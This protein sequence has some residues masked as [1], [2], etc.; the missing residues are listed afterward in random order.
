MATIDWDAV[1]EEA[2]DLLSRYIAIDTSNPPGREQ[3]AADFLAGIL[4]ED[5]IECQIY[6]IA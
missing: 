3:A 4:R 1:T 6:P 5:G 2:T